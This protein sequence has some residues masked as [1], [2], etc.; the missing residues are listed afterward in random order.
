M[1]AVR[2]LFVAIGNPGE[3]YR[4]TRHN[5]GFL[6][7][8]YFIDNYFNPLA[9]VN[10][11]PP[12]LEKKY[13][14]LFYKQDLKFQQ[15]INSQLL[16]KYD[17]ID[18]IS[19]RRR[20]KTKTKGVAYPL[21]NLMLYKPETFINLSGT[22]V[23]EV[24]DK[25]HFK[26]KKNPVS[27]N[28]MDEILVIHDDVSLPFGTVKMSHQASS[29]NHN[30]IKSIESKL[31]KNQKYGRLRIGAMKEGQ[32]P[33]EYVLHKLSVIEQDKLPQLFNFVGEVLRVY[34]FRGMEDAE[35]VCNT[36]K[37]IIKD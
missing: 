6:A 21:V 16:H 37:Q 11:P 35:M 29:A 27:L 9:Q 36:H 13:S 25:E 4:L 33:I 14:G 17:M 3:K 34:L 10:G 22:G 19:E 31:E 7:L 12:K 26:L 20:N 8:D 5:L 1:Y 24:L 15:E 32:K 30:G 23:R 2:R 18:E 28:K